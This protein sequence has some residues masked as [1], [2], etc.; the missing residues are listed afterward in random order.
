VKGLDEFEKA[1]HTIID[2]VEEAIRKAHPEIDKF[3]SELE[4]DTLLLGEA[5]YDLESE[6]ADMLRESVERLS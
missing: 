6:I 5:Y 3:A 2:M 1:A 4:G